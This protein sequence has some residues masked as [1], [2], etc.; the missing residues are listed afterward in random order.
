MLTHV[1]RGVATVMNFRHLLSLS[2]CISLLAGCGLGSQPDNA[3]SPTEGSPALSETDSVSESAAKLSVYVTN[4]PLK[5]MAE[6]IGGDAVSVRFPVPDDVDPVFWS[7]EPEAISEMQKADLIFL[8]GATYEKWLPAV[9]LPQ[10]SL[11]DTS[12]GFSDRFIAVQDVVTHSHGPEGDHSHAGI[13]FTTWIDFQLAIEQGRAIRDALALQLP[14]RQEDFEANFAQ[15][16]RALLDLDRQLEDAIA[17]SE[18]KDQP[19]LA[20]HPVY[21]YLAERYGLNLR[22]ILWEPE[23]VPDESEWQELEAQLRDRPATAMIWEGTPDA[24]S[25][26]RLQGLDVTSVVFAP[27][28]NVPDSGD[29]LDVM[30]A[31]T[32]ALLSLF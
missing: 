20:S 9:S 1:A 7:P 12:A 8:N 29:F 32:E 27:V 17:N 15:L 6:Q 21:D 3:A 5:F 28:G 4:Y 22:S 25:V 14:D 16:E 30:Q 19:L 31:N 2:L 11:V 26:A 13:A 10:G 23:V 18:R 24:Q